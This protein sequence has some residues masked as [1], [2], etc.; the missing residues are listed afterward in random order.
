[1]LKIFFFAPKRDDSTTHMI[2]AKNFLNSHW[3]EFYFGWICWHEIP[4]SSLQMRF[5]PTDRL[6]DSDFADFNFVNI[7]DPMLVIYQHEDHIVLILY[8]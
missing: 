8:T 7:G 2:S 6:T 1:M 4:K 3:V 5:F